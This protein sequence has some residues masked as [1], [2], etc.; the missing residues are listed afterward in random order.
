MAVL[1]S[2]YVVFALRLGRTLRVV[3]IVGRQSSAPGFFG[4]DR[5]WTGTCGLQEYFESLQLMGGT[6]SLQAL[7]AVVLER[8]GLSL[9]LPFALLIPSNL[10]EL[11]RNSLVKPKAL[12]GS[13]MSSVCLGGICAVAKELGQH[14]RIELTA[15]GGEDGSGRTAKLQAVGKMLAGSNNANVLDALRPWGNELELESIRSVVDAM[16]EGQGP[17][18]PRGVLPKEISPANLPGLRFG[19]ANLEYMFT[20]DQER[21]NE[22]LSTVCNR[23]CGNMLLDQQ[24]GEAGKFGVRVAGRLCTTLEDFISALEK[25][26]RVTFEIRTN[27]TS[28]GIGLSILDDAQKAEEALNVPI[29]FPIKTNIIIPEATMTGAFRKHEELVSLMTH[30]AVFVKVAGPI[31]ND[32]LLE[33]CLNVN[34]MTGFQGVGGVSRPWQ[35]APGAY[36][37][38]TPGIFS[39]RRKRA[40]AARLMS[41]ISAVTNA[42][43]DADEV[44]LG[45]YGYFGVCCDSTALLQATLMNDTDAMTIYPLLLGGG[46]KVCLTDAYEKFA[47]AHPAWRKDARR[48]RTSLGHLPCDIIVED[49]SWCALRCLS[50]MPTQSIFTAVD[51]IRRQLERVVWQRKSSTRRHSR[52]RANDHTSYP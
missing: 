19:N 5:G 3:R 51:G 40:R 35:T 18:E 10:F 20:V 36:V 32:A 24:G 38:H 1:V 11:D 52:A 34:G 42:Q 25:D 43:A 15:S 50:S 41:I 2:V 13:L 33:W 31:V 37:V 29:C 9:A 49:Q 46:A 23:L 16:R 6:L 28:M 17:D 22:V 45:G 4:V 8:F 12:A 21:T 47:A 44:V 7:L 14:A 48:L 39:T 26:H 27:I 30:A